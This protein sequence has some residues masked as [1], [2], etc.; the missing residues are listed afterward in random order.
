MSGFLTVPDT[1]SYRISNATLA[2]PEIGGSSAVGDL[3]VRDGRISEPHDGTSI[4]VQ[5][6]M[7]FPA[8]SDMHTHIDKGHVWP[9][10]PN[11]DGT[12]DSA[13]RMAGLDRVANWSAEDVRRRMD[14][15]LR[16]AY[17]HGTQSLRTHLDSMPPQHRVSWPVFDEVRRDWSDRIELQAVTIIGVDAVDEDPSFMEVA[18]TAARYGGVLGC[19]TFPIADIDQRLDRFLRI[20]SER[21]MAVDFHAD[22]TE[23]SSSDTLASIA[24]AVSRTGFD[25]PAVVGHCCSLS[26][27]SKDKADRI[28]DLVAEAGLSIVSLPMCNQYLQDR[29]EGRTP[30]W[31]GTT[32]V[33]EMQSR[34]IPVSFASDNTRDPFYAYGDLDMIEVLQQAT[35]IC[36][37]DHAGAPWLDS[38]TEIPAVTCGFSNSGRLDPGNPASFVLCKARN[39][40]EFLS[41]PQSDRVVVRNGRQ[42]LTELPCYSELD[43][44]MEIS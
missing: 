39:W 33:H 9:R 19:F 41:R 11:D 26:R 31:R 30:Q 25:A 5:R 32:L 37:L 42:V 40:S 35:R 13:L 15:S 3:F 21:G 28:L 17:F 14:F 18:D 10:A 8:F 22:E 1:N 36:H 34:G 43:D 6:A 44:L 27:Q 20:A 4:D 38:F 29:H 16:C 12:F 7:L 23:D 2:S 24:R